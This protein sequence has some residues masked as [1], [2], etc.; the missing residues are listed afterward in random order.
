MA[1][2]KS[3]IPDDLEFKQRFYKKDVGDWINVGNS[4]IVN[5]E[6]DFTQGLSIKRAGAPPGRPSMAFFDALSQEREGKEGFLSP[7]SLGV[8]SSYKPGLRL[9]LKDRLIDRPSF[10]ESVTSHACVQR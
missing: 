8:E 7:M 4:A 10:M 6:G 3:D 5:P 9:L 2:R 1:L